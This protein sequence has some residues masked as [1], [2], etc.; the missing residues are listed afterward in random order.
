MYHVIIV[1]DD[2]MVASI[3]RRY[4]ESSAAFCVDA[5]FKSGSE[6]LEYFG[7]NTADLVILDYFTPLMTGAEFIDKLHA[8]GK[9]PAVIM[10]TSANDTDIVRSLLRRGV[11]DYLVKPFAYER[12]QAALERFLERVRHLESNR[13]GFDQESLDRMMARAMPNASP[14]RQ[15]P[16][17]KGLNESTLGLVRNFLK[18]NPDSL[19]TSEQIAEQIH[20]SRITIRRYMNYMVDCGELR[21]V[22]DYRTGGRPSIKYGF[23]KPD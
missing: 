21:S 18:E 23:S 14:G 15:R 6:G 12:F 10:V 3:N 4:V 17:A 7:K 8:L 11:I 20:L 19:F 5:V 16:L 1:E 2:P 9:T 13:D 22:I